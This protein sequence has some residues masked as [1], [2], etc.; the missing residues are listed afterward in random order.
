MT[1]EIKNPV[2]NP[3]VDLGEMNDNLPSGNEGTGSFRAGLENSKNQVINAADELRTA[4]EAKARELRS[5]AENKANELRDRAQH[6]YGDARERVEQA[7]GDARERA[8]T[9]QEDGEQYVRDNPTRAI[10]TALAAG[11][12]LGLVFRR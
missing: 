5:T 11:F 2:I 3:E 7:Y 1:E 8:R 9:L 6:A 12:V 10:A 4:A